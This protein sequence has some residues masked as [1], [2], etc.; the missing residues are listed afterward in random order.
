MRLLTTFEKTGK[1]NK[2]VS[3]SK[4]ILVEKRHNAR[5]RNEL[6]YEGRP[7]KNCGTTTKYTSSGKCVKCLPIL[8]RGIKILTEGKKR[9]KL[10]NEGIVQYESG[11]LCKHG[12][13]GL[14]YTKGGSCV[15]CDKIKWQKILNDPK[16]HAHAM[17]IKKNYRDK[18]SSKKKSRNRV[19]QKKYGITL[20]EQENM[21]GEQ[22][23][24]CANSFCDTKFPTLKERLKSDGGKN[25]QTDHDHQTG[26]VRGLLCNVCNMSLGII[27]ELLKF[28]IDTNIQL[29]LTFNKIQR[30]LY[31][32]I[33]THYK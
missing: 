25:M 27:E 1:H 5:E 29:P 8:G 23:G 21:Y 3:K 4:A 28:L 9:Q 13:R 7:C 16:K 10:Y 30:G 14:R 11:I 26:K 32:Y 6:T 12:H 33:K 19:L 20:E 18:S 17:K 22:D 2:Y 31:L 24:I 15:E